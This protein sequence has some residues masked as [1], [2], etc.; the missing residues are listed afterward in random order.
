M[1]LATQTSRGRVSHLTESS[2]CCSIA[3]RHIWLKASTGSF[4]REL[5][6]EVI[7]RAVV[8]TV[9]DVDVPAV[10]APG[11]DDGFGECVAIGLQPGTGVVGDRLLRR[12]QL[13]VQD[14]YGA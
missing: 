10:A 4:L 9:G 12:L 3:S 11:V 2:K 1:L 13:G 14:M 6:V 8:K 7:P 5:D